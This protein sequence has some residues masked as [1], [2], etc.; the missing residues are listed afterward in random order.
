MSQINTKTVTI[1]DLI[2]FHTEHYAQRAEWH[3][4][5][6]ERLHWIIRQAAR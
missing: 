1:N 4:Q 3:R 2:E 6:V 5:A